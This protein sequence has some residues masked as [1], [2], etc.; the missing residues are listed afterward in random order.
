[1]SNLPKKRPTM[2]ATRE[3]QIPSASA[4]SLITLE[5]SYLANLPRNDKRHK[6][7]QDAKLVAWNN[8]KLNACP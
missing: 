1:L 2:P 5:T 3:S 6:V 4:T 8:Q 7:L